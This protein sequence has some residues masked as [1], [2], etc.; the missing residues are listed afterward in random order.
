MLY[1]FRPLLGGQ[2]AFYLLA[3]LGELG[4]RLG[5]LCRTFVVLNSAAVVG[6]WRFVTGGQKITW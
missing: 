6:L 1:G 4:G 5:S 2:M 3:V